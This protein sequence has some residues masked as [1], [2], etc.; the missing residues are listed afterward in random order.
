MDKVKEA[1]ALAEAAGRILLES[2]AEIYRVEETVLSVCRAM[3]F[4]DSQVLA[5]PTGVFLTLRN[6]DGPCGSTVVRV[7]HRQLNLDRI[8]EANDVARHLSEL[9]P[10]AALAR[11]EEI[12]HREPYPRWLLFLAA[13]LAAG[14]FTFI[15]GGGVPEA[16]IAA[17]AGWLC[18]LALR[19]L[20]PLPHS[21]VLENLFGGLVIGLVSLG[22]VLLVGHGELEVIIA[23][24]VMPLLPG[25]AMTVAI[26]DTMQGDLVSGVARLADVILTA[27]C[28]AVGTGAVLGLWTAI[29]G[30]LP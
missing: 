24:A 4:G 19:A 28:V 11:M 22:A 14:S 16:L 18:H 20:G 21:P 9:G 27:A 7:S 26:R 13:G 17:L 2:G 6:A 3:G 12:R 10:E 8:R 1:L 15:F 5:I 23:G 29:G 25:L 30:M